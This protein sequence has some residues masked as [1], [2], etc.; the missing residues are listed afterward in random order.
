LTL[1]IPSARAGIENT[2]NPISKPIDRPRLNFFILFKYLLCIYLKYFITYIERTII[3]DNIKIKIDFD[4]DQLNQV[5]QQIISKKL[6]LQTSLKELENYNFN[7][8]LG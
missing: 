3:M 6:N 4:K 1:I 7:I 5:F 2:R 8:F